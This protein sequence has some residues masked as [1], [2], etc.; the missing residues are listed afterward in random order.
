M[1]P[2][3]ERLKASQSLSCTPNSL[4]IESARLC[5]L[6][7]LGAAQIAELANNPKLVR[8]KPQVWS[9]PALKEVRC[10][11]LWPHFSQVSTVSSVK[12]AGTRISGLPHFGQPLATGMMIF[13]VIVFPPS[14]R[15]RLFRLLARITRLR[16]SF[17]FQFADYFCAGKKQHDREPYPRK[18]TCQPA[19]NTI[20][21]IVRAEIRRV[22]REEPGPQKPQC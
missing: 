7:P 19:K 22:P 12:S 10:G 13:S 8:V 21:F 15:F 3:V 18:E 17:S 11:S 1:E 9:S 4:Q 14:R 16:L 2:G 5:L 20:S 6:L